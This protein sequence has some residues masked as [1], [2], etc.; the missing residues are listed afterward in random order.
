MQFTQLNFNE[1]FTIQNI[2]IYFIVINIIGFFIMWLDKRKA[3]KG[4]WR[5]P[6]KTLFIITALGG[7]I[8]TIAGMYTFRHKTQKIQ[9][10]IGFPVITIL[11]IMTIIYFVL[12]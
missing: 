8:G 1:I 11:E 3:I 12:K 5:I 7:G 2:I 6:E 4:S 10:V 9:F